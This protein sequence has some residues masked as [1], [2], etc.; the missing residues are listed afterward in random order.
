MFSPKNAFDF[1][2]II[3]ALNTSIVFILLAYSSLSYTRGVSIKSQRA[4]LFFTYFYLMYN[5][6][7]AFNVFNAYNV[8][9]AYNAYKNNSISERHRHRFEFNNSF[10]EDLVSVGLMPSGLSP[11]G[12]LVEIVEHRDHPFMAGT[13]FH[14]EF[15][16]RPT[17]PHPLFRE[18][19]GASCETLSLERQT[20]LTNGTGDH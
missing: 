2:Y 5:V 16:S 13:Q 11:D 6:F 4:I 18:F 10:R 8:C 9:N 19:V 20:T 12:R 3:L 1:E 7:N 14:P 15:L 17:K